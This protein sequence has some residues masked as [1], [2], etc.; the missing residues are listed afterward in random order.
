MSSSKWA[1]FMK[2]LGNDLAKSGGLL[3]ENKDTELLQPGSSGLMYPDDL[4]AHGHQAFIFFNIRSSTDKASPSY[5][6]MCLYMPKGLTVHYGAN[7]K[8]FSAPLEKLVTTLGTYANSITDAFSKMRQ[9]AANFTPSFDSVMSAITSTFGAAK[10][11]PGAQ[12][13]LHNIIKKELGPDYAAEYRKSIGKTVNPFAALVYESPEFRTF[14][15][16]F[17]FTPK[18]ASEANEVRKIIKLF[19]LAMHPAK[20]AGQDEELF[21]DFPYVFDVYLCTPWT[22]KMFMIKRCALESAD[23]DYAPEGVQSFFKDGHPVYTKLELKFK[24][25]E[26]LTRDEIENNY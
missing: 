19:K 14:R 17:D 26:L 7:W 24:E 22:D 15:F 12:Y 23:V 25:L 11:D 8:D 21:W 10:N 5:G 20:R 9:G 3:N 13:L 1:T 4:F 18:N 6:S 16:S 2:T